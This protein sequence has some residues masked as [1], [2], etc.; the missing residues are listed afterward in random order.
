LVYNRRVNRPMIPNPAT[1]PVAAIAALLSAALIGCGG[2]PPP[3]DQVAASQAAIRAAIEVGGTQEPQ[4]ALHL[5]LAR[6]QMDRAKGLME[7][8][9]NE[10]ALRVLQ[11][12]EAD[13][14]LAR[15]LAKKSATQASAEEAKTKVVKL[16]SGAPK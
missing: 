3:N 4:A 5:K 10:A 1:S 11:R 15:A 13:A 7:E 14:E 8:G 6:E 12:A 9:E 16:K 2:L